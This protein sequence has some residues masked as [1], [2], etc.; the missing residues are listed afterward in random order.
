MG[1]VGMAQV[2]ARYWLSQQRSIPKE[3]AGTII[4]RLAWRG[5]S[6]FPLTS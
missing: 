2:S 4:S 5:I 1:L 3:T 6:G